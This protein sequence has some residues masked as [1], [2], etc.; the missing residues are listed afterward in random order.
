MYPAESA[1]KPKF[2]PEDYIATEFQEKFSGKLNALSAL[3]QSIRRS[4]RDRVVLV[5]HST[6]ALTMFENLLGRLKMSFLRLDGS[7]DVRKR[8]SLVNRFNDPTSEAFVFLLS[9]KAGGVGINLVGVRVVVEFFG[10]SCSFTDRRKPIDS[11]R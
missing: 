2:L 8:Q 7:T 4:T 11:F 5:S 1:I 10:L 6:K 9:T 3:L